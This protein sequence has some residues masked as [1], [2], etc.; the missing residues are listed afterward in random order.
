LNPGAID[1]CPT[2]LPVTPW[3]RPVVVVSVQSLVV[4]CNNPTFTIETLSP[5]K[6]AT[7]KIQFIVTS[8]TVFLYSWRPLGKLDPLEF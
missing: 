7:K 1:L 8:S 5:Q 4:V 3:K 2:A 6:K